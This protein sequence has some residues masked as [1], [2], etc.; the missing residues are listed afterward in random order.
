MTGVQTCALPIC[1]F[2]GSGVDTLLGRGGN[3]ILQGGFFT[4]TVDGGSG[5]DLIQI[6]DG[7]FSDNVDGGTGTDTLDVSDVLLDPLTLDLSAGTYTLLGPAN[8]IIGVENVS[9]T[10]VADT[11]TGDG[12]VNTFDGNGGND[13]MTGGGGVDIMRGGFGNDT[14]FVDA[15]GEAFEL[16]GQGND[17]VRSTV[18]YNLAGQNIERLFLLANNI[19]GTGNVLSNFLVG[20]AGTQT[21]NGAGGNDNL[22]GAGGAD[23]FVFNTA[24]DPIG[25]VDTITDFQV[26]V[27]EIRLENAV[28]VGLPAGPLA[29]AAFRI[30]PAAADANDRIIYNDV[31]GELIFDSNG[32]AAGG[33]TQFATLDP[34]LALTASDFTVF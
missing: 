32:N 29:A 31:T 27:D 10:Q 14:Y 19:S 34:G 17:T 30:G 22:T 24:L 4:D 23:N 11:I 28:F 7:E 20:S 16:G 33:D 9:G 3:D 25:N 26:G 18:S 1:L 13:T 21:L 15:Q 8:T 12:A 2:G 5:N 6:L